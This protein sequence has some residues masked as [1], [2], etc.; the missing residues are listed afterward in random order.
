MTRLVFFDESAAQRTFGS[1][2]ATR[3][4]LHQ[5]IL[6]HHRVRARRRRDIR[7]S[8][9]ADHA[10]YAVLLPAVRANN[11]HTKSTFTGMHAHRVTEFQWLTL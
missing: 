8:I 7:P 3:F 9:H 6:A 10:L 11:P 4:E 1:A 2:V 5:A